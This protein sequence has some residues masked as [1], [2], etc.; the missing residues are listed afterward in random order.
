[1]VPQIEDENNSRECKLYSHSRF[2]CLHK[3]N[4][5]RRYI[6]TKLSDKI[7]VLLSWPKGVLAMIRSRLK[8]LL[9]KKRWTQAK[10]AQVTGIRPTTLSNIARDMIVRVPVEDLDLICEA[11]NC[12]PGELYEWIPN[13]IPRIARNRNGEPIRPIKD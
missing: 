3:I 8:E 10:L 12:Q 11:L 9:G 7:S 5:A 13:D 2:L 6:V 1:M 4:N